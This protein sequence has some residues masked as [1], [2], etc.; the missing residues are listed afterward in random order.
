M[1][2]KK[3]NKKPDGAGSVASEPEKAK[4][5]GNQ[6]K[7]NADS[8]FSKFNLIAGTLTLAASVAT[9]GMYF[10]TRETLRIEQRA[11]VY[12]KDKDLVGINPAH[13]VPP[14]KTGGIAVVFQNSGPTPAL[15]VTHWITACVKIGTLPDDFS[16]PRINPN[17]MKYFI[18]P[19]SES[20]DIV[21]VPETDLEQIRD[22]KAVVFFWGSIAYSDVFNTTHH[23]DFCYFYLGKAVGPE[24]ADQIWAMCPQHNCV[25]EDCPDKWGDNADEQECPQAAKPN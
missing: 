19:Q 13:P 24:G 16:Y 10:L 8:V 6:E 15:G 12:V 17:G 23:T 9:I 20:K 18:P 2:R 4:G 25:D 1:S 3:R 21:R 5:Y 22:N 14:G 11:F 7:K